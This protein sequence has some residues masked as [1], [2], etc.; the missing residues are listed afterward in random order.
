[1]S[2]KNDTTSIKSGI[3]ETQGGSRL[4]LKIEENGLVN[5]SYATSH[6]RPEDNEF[7]P[8]TGWVN[9]NLISLCCCWG[10]YRSMTTWCGRYYKEENGQETIKYMWHLAREFEDR[11]QTIENNLTFTFHTMSGTFIYKASQ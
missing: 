11:K 3:W 1:M 8:V 9:H 6:G 2:Y 5:G 10:E 4:I 7:F